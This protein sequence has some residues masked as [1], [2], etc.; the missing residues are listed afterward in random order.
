MRMFKFDCCTSSPDHWNE[1]HWSL[2]VR[3][4]QFG[5]LNYVV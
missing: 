4:P 3:R 2:L 5:S 1:A